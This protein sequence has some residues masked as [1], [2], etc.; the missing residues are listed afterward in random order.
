MIAAP[1][2]LQAKH[3]VSGFCC[4]VDSLDE[5]LIRRA[6]QN[7]LS[8]AS[9]TF[10][11]CEGHKVIAYYC[12]ASC[13]VTTTAAFGRFRRNMPDPIPVVVLGR[14]AIDKSLQHQGMGR[15]LV[16]DAGLRVIQVAETIGIRGMMVHALSNEARA[17]YLRTGFEPSPIDPMLL[18]ITLDD[19][20]AAVKAV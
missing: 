17:F 19:L 20:L 9:R 16:R 10:V 15:A 3:E 8:G 11:C 2:V 12:L 14:L 5:W 4:G 1:E 6:L 18:M 7:Q 13:S